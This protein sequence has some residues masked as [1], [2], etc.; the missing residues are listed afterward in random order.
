M[1]R[2]RS[3][4]TLSVEGSFV[5]GDGLSKV[6]RVLIASPRV[7]AKGDVA[8]SELVEVEDG[9]VSS[10]LEDDAEHSSGFRVAKD[11]D[12]ERCAGDAIAMKVDILDSKSHGCPLSQGCQA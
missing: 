4:G 1:S 2:L 6:G 9:N 7:L 3:I 10:L 11:H 12:M 8:K 5:L